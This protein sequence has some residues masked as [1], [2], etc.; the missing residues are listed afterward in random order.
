MK[1]SR[2]G[3]LVAAI[4]SPLLLAE[5]ITE[6][7]AARVQQVLEAALL[8]HGG[9]ERLDA[10]KTLRV[11]VVDSNIAVGQ[12]RRAEPPLDRAQSRGQTA[13]D[14][15]NS[16]FATR[17]AGVGGGYEF[18]N[19][20]VINADQSYQLDFNQGTRAKIAE[21]D[22]A[23]TSGPFVRVSPTLLVLQLRDRAQN[24]YYLGQSVLDSKRFDVVGL[25]MAVGPGLSLYFDAQTHLL[26]RSERL[27]PGFGMVEYRFDDYQTVDG[28]P[29]NAKF[30]LLI[31]G[32]ESLL[33]TNLRTQI[34]ADLDDLV[35]PVK[36]LADIPPIVPQP[37]RLVKLTDKVFHVGGNG[38]YAMFIDQGDHYVAVGGTGGI[39]ERLE[40]LRAEVGDK[41]VRY[42]AMTHHHSDHILGVG[43]YEAAGATIIG[44]KTHEQV[45]RAA[46]ADADALKFQPVEKLFT[47]GEGASRVEFVDVG[48]TAH[49]EHLILAWLPGPKILFEAD[50]FAM[51]AAGAVQAAATPTQEFAAAL[52]R[53]QL[54]PKQIASAHSPR[55][56]TM[57]DLERALELAKDD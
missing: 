13:I 56:G 7:S 23:T 10:I 49:V 2:M 36:H 1:L 17:N 16:V 35:E 24:A 57:A 50:H 18:E 42:A 27:L 12:S 45:I 28:V 26:R 3:L 31:N 54:A 34:N 48:P 32:E 33:R 43:A 15:S 6:T 53:L 41:P 51:P 9:A 20:T 55:T 21:P 8:A 40:M 29:V 19:G 22:F 38:T 37:L 39:S 5:N 25:S 52:K 30:T 46:A 11:E 14:L 44:A 47:L 4:H